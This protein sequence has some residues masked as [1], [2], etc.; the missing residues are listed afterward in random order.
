MNFEW[1][2]FSKRVCR[3]VALAAALSFA[4]GTVGLAQVGVTLSGTVVD[5]QGLVLPGTTIELRLPD[6]TF[7]TST[8]ADRTGGFIL[9]G[10][11]HRDY[12]VIAT[13]QGFRTVERPV[14]LEADTSDYEIALDVGGFEQEIVVTAVMPEVATE[15][16]M[17]ARE[18]ERRAVRDV[19]AALR[20][21][22]GVNAVRRG[23][24]NLEPTIR[25]LFEAQIGMFVDGTRTFA[26]GPARMD[27]DI[28]H[29]SPHMMQAV[30]VVKGPYALTWG[31]G[32]LSAIQVET[33]KP[34]FSG[35]E[36]VVG[37]QAG[38]TYSGNG[39][40][41]DGFAGL[42]GRSDRVRFTFLHNTRTGSDYEDGDGNVVPGNFE[43]FE[44]RWGLGLRPKPE[45][46]V[47]YSGGYQ[48]QN[49]INFP[50]RLLD[51]A[52]FETQSHAFDVGYTPRSG[53]VSEV[54]GQ[55]Y[56]NLKDHAMNNDS[57]PTAMNMPGRVPPFAL[58]VNIDTTSDTVG[59]RFH[60]AL[61]QGT[62]NY[63]AGLDIFH[64]AQN[65]NR[66][67]AR[68]SNGFLIFSDIVWPD[69]TVV[70]TGGYGQVVYDRGRA[71]FGG[72]VRVDYEDVS[73]GE[74]SQF[75]RD[76]TTGELDQ[77]DASVSAAVNTSVRVTETMVLNLGLG[78]AVRQPTVMERYSDR[79]PA[80]KFQIAAEFMGNPALVAEESLE[81]NIGAVVRVLE[82]TLEG[83]FFYRHIDNY[84]TVLPDPSLSRRLPLSPLP[85]YRYINGDAARFT[86]YDVKAESPVGVY[87]DLR[88]GWTYTWAE[89][90]FFDEPLFGI[91]PFEQRYALNV[92]TPNRARWVELSVTN[93]AAQ[94]RVA[95]MRF[96]QPTQ[97]WT[98]VD[99][100]AGLA[101][102]EGFTIKLGLENLT[103]EFYATHVNSLNPFTRQRIAEI[104]RSFYFGAEYGF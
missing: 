24:I 23:P 86:G 26:A 2:T 46:T 16:V 100:L 10:L 54:F 95:Q 49:D 69:A 91:A 98:R 7:V 27:S 29:V 6:R 74:V 13:L 103:D 31:S 30:R 44:T 61:D 33:F 11:A 59:G 96:E 42:W 56:A 89:D 57:K 68:Q 94:D 43:S 51:A 37:A 25:G 75:F 63:K 102:A 52:F 36:F 71:R 81:F 47:E 45:L 97:G 35:G 64:L 4:G 15:L 18:V 55:V 48:K 88:A 34:A 19:A 79:F 99:L 84:I 87:A 85:V 5:A 8:Y 66:T 82:A 39:D 9:S 32:T 70:N 73:A 83:D 76:N 90:S 58:D 67:V 50:G 21:E 28:S 3:V 1:R 12:L 72:T 77:S 53:R 38:Y 101:V 22:S 93:A 14:S 78:R 20:E 40:S 104:G 60:V 41:N 92:H 17:T 65:A 80:T 62:L